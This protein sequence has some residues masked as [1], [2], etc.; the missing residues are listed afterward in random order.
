[1]RSVR[2]ATMARIVASAAIVAAAGAVIGGGTFSAFSSTTQNAGNSFAAG[3]VA[4]GDND[5]GAAL[6]SVT[7]QEPGVSLE[8]CIKV[9]YTGSLDADVKLYT[10]SPIGSL[11]PYVNLTITPGSQATPTF[12]ACT[13]FVADSGGAI[14]TG[15]LASFAT[16]HSGY[17]NGLADYPGATGAW[18]ANDA[19]V[20]RYAVSL[21]DDNAA[22]GG[23]SALATGA[24]AFTWESRNQ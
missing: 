9:T 17:S 8:R 2:R 12:P 20:Y 14:F 23:A 6:Y 13:G 21:A 10:S 15:T 3:T 22:N 7:N 16:A 1:M 4:I 18:A 5:A 24:H 19:V 11:G